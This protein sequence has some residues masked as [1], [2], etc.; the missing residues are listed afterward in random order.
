MKR[1]FLLF[2][3]WLYTAC[4]FIASSCVTDRSVYFILCSHKLLLTEETSYKF[5]L[6][7]PSIYNIWRWRSCNARTQRR[8]HKQPRS[9]PGCKYRTEI[10]SWRSKTC[11][12]STNSNLILLRRHGN[13]TM[14]EHGL[15]F[16]LL[17][18]RNK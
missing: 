3:C 14:T 16:H 10:S 13:V 17:V 15:L 18:T 1:H 5:L 7:T 9:L 6:L 12:F 8:T 4:L 11:N 2:L